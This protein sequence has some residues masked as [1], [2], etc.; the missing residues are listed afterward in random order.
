MRGKRKTYSE[1][2]IPKAMWILLYAGGAVT[3][4]FAG[5]FGTENRR[6]Q[7]LMICA[8]ASIIGFMLFMIAAIDRPFEG[9]VSVEPEPFKHALENLQQLQN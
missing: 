2:E 9:I 7:I 8:L 6:L 1:S 3:L 4:L 5:L